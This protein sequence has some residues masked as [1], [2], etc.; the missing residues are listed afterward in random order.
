MNEEAKKIL[1]A[2]FIREVQYTTRLANVVIVKKSNEKWRMCINYTHL[3]K[4]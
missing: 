1:S 2:G 4:A 3:K